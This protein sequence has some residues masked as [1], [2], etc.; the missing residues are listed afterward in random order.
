MKLEN[1]LKEIT[2][3]AHKNLEDVINFKNSQLE[4]ESL[5]IN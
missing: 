2:E 3:I 5:Q 4:E 1:T